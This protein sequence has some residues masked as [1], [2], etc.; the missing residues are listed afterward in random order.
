MPVAVYGFL[1]SKKSSNVMVP[2]GGAKPP[3][4]GIGPRLAL[5]GA[6]AGAAA[7]TATAGAGTGAGTGAA[8]GADLAATAAT[9][10]LAS[11]RG[12]NVVVP[13][14]ADAVKYL[15][16]GRTGRD[17]RPLSPGAHVMISVHQL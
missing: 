12:G 4:V 14:G 5:A 1:L 7:A 9:L 13:G 17:M 2:E 15:C 11:G 6:G 10:G 8:L 16:C 3:P